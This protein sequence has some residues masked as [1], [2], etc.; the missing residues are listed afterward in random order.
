M[1]GCSRGRERHGLVAG[2]GMATAKEGKG[3]GKLVSMRA[4]DGAW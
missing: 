4:I 3:S 2:A 1:T